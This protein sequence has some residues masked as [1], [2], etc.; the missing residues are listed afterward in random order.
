MA[1]TSLGRIPGASKGSYAREVRRCG[2]GRECVRVVSGK[3]Q[4]CGCERRSNLRHGYARKGVLRP[5]W[6][7]W[8][9]MIQRCTN[10]ND[11]HWKDYGQRGI[12][13][14]EEWS[15]SFDAFIRDMG[16]KPSPE[17]SLD[18]IDANSGYCKSNCRW[19][20]RKTQSQNRRSVIW[21]EH[22]G[23]RMCAADW[24]LATGMKRQTILSR[25]HRGLSTDEI[26]A[27]IGGI[28]VQN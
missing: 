4:S 19:A 20:D 26:F 11:K 10:P 18:R 28:E 25:F 17:H 1:W 21:I 2:C 22:D 3:S 23:Q 24:A 27:P 5:E 14:C 16:D 7:A 15:M 13:V 6:Q 9:H 12:T 8:N